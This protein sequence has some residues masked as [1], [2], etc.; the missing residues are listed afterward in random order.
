MRHKTSDAWQ[1]YMGTPDTHDAVNAANHH[2]MA[3][4]EMPGAN[5]RCLY[6]SRLDSLAL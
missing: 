5:G 1:E 3:L 2:G 4:R 6:F